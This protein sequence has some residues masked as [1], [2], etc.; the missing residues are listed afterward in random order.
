[1]VSAGVYKHCFNP[2]PDLP[3]FLPYSLGRH[4][5]MPYKSPYIGKAHVQDNAK[6]KSPKDFEQKFLSLRGIEGGPWEDSSNSQPCKPAPLLYM[7]AGRM[8]AEGRS[9]FFSHLGRK[10]RKL[11][12]A[13]LSLDWSHR[14]NC[15]DLQL[16]TSPLIDLTCLIL[17]VRLPHET[18]LK[19][20]S[21]G[22]REIFRFLIN[23]S[24][25]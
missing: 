10:Y 7:A 21:F 3:E 22:E 20:N 16:E 5:R 17:W 19:D 2:H 18:G 9:E 13:R 25:L 1:M 6:I 12:G 24:L 4:Q 11:R 15:R 14:T 23:S 8:L